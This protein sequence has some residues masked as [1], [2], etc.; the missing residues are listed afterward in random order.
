MARK[1]FFSFHYDNDVWRA[2]QVRNSWVTKPDR[3]TAGFMDH[4]DFEQLKR[5]GDAAVKSWIDDQLFG[6]TVTV[7]LIGS[8]TLQR[9]FVKYE[10]QKSLDRGNAIIGIFIGKV[11]NASGFTTTRCSTDVVIGNKNGSPVNF[12]NLPIYD[13]VDNDGYANLGKWVEDAAN[14]QR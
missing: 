6:S 12:K 1:V 14:S 13:W 2:N 7:V 3:Q 4:A 8:E 10:L 5:R 11:K 9:P